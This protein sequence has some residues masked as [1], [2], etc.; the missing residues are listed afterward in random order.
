MC[1]K[2]N[3]KGTW[4]CGPGTRSGVLCFPPPPA[5]GISDENDSPSGKGRRGK[6]K[7]IFH[8]DSPIASSPVPWL[9]HSDEFVHHRK[10]ELYSTCTYSTVLYCTSF[11]KYTYLWHNKKADAFTVPYPIVAAAAAKNSQDFAICGF[12]HHSLSFPLSP[13]PP[14]AFSALL[15]N[16]TR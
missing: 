11:C 4:A 5:G 14:P 10:A 1:R 12:F 6:R 13:R 16:Q 15:T 2:V 9:Y 7:M 3:A 8:V